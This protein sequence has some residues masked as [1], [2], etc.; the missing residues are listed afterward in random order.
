MICLTAVLLLAG[1]QANLAQTPQEPVS[2]NSEA[3]EWHPYER[4]K[5]FIAYLCGAL[6]VTSTSVVHTLVEQHNAI[7]ATP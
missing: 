3:S 4:F 5:R 2:R 6:L 1:L 7:H